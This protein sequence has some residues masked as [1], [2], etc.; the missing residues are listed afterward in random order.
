GI[1]VPRVFF[2]GGMGSRHPAA[3]HGANGG[4]LGENFHQCVR[5]LAANCSNVVFGAHGMTPTRDGPAIWPIA[6]AAMGSRGGQRVSKMF[7]S[8]QLRGQV[9]EL[10][11]FGKAMR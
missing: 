2:D 1:A 4:I 3:A 9:A 5:E 10:Q 6:F 11:A 7:R 8:P